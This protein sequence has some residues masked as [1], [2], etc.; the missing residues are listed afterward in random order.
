MSEMK[1]REATM[2]TVA[3]A[4]S[5]LGAAVL[6][7]AVS[8]AAT[9]QAAKPHAGNVALPAVQRSTPGAT[10]GFEYGGKTAGST[11]GFEYGGR[12]AA[13][14]KTR[15]FEYG[16]KSASGGASR[17]FEYGGLHARTSHSHTPG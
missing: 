9:A 17:G 15:G 8:L 3:R 6:V 13:S 4:T 2:N 1:L 10:H 14:G 16:G 5:V 11:H 12:S 7:L